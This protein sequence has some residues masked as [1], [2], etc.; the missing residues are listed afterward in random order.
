MPSVLVPGDNGINVIVNYDQ[1]AY[2]ALA[3]QFVGPTSL[4]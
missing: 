4:V 2:A 1:P 3:Q